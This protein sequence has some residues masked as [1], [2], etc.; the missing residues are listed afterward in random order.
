MGVLAERHREAL[1]NN[2]TRRLSVSAPTETWRSLFGA[3]HAKRL[4]PAEVH[5]VPDK[6]R[7]A[8]CTH[9]V[10]LLFVLTRVNFAAKMGTSVV[11]IF[12]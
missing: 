12:P 4:A 6:V 2:L 5:V 9:S 10:E 1:G 3:G 8:D 7:S 11:I